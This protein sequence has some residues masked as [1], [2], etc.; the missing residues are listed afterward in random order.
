[1]SRPSEQRAGAPELPDEAWLAALCA[2]DGA[3]PRRIEALL[4]RWS[5]HEAWTAVAAGDSGVAGAIESAAV[6]D[7]W[8]RE[9]QVIDAEVL[10]G[11]HVDARV[12]VLGASS[13]AFPVRLRDDP[14][15]P[16]VLFTW[17]DPT[18][19][20]G[21]T[22]AIVGTRDCTRYGIDIAN[23]LGR[24]LAEA[25]VS[26]VSGLA[27]GIDA[28]AH[29]GALAGNGAPPIGV[30]G[31][32]VDR[33]Y[34]ARNRALWRRVG[35]IGV[36]CS[37]APLGAAPRRWRFPARNRLIAGLAEVVIVVESHATGGSLSTATE[38]MARARPVL[39]VPGSIRSPASAG[40][41]RLIDDGCTPLCTLDDVL[42]ALE[43]TAATTTGTAE[44]AVV[45]PEA[46]ALLDV[47][48][49][50]PRPVDE[51]V[52]A[53][54]EA[55][56]VVALRIELLVGAGLIARRG[57]LIERTARAIRVEERTS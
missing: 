40:T 10:W 49:W 44:V 13:P 35:E 15:P 33:P 32:G 1:M 22:A 6:A 46:A 51:V 43:L 52:L 34:P 7:R 53:T 21:R 2:L 5:P 23:E 31:S 17:G 29:A 18:V 27:A 39:A 55:V 11:E 9:A 38:A 14:E 25:G 26:V 28:A 3:G 8:R 50:Q 47:I 41:N 20:S 24:M 45:D 30:V 42:V 48:G 56:D 54:G 16:I 36:V 4:D 37:E 19:F 57:P 12:G